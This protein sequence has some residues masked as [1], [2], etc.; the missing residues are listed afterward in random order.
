MVTNTFWLLSL[1]RIQVQLLYFQVLMGLE[2]FLFAISFLY[3]ITL[4]TGDGKSSFV[5]G[6]HSPGRGFGALYITGRGVFLGLVEP[7]HPASTAKYLCR[8][9]V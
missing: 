4:T 8:G 6:H 2:G 7:A 1:L 3:S 9:P 5:V